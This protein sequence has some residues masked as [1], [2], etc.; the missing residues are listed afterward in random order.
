MYV[1]MYIRYSCHGNREDQ[2][3]R[4]LLVNVDQAKPV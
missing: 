3:A 2:L 1:H 4:R